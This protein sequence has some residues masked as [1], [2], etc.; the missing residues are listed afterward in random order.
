MR[1]F[2]PETEKSHATQ[3]DTMKTDA[4]TRLLK[5]AALI[6]NQKGF[7]NAGLQELL[8]KARVPKG[9]FYFHFKSKEDFGLKLVDFYADFYLGKADQI[10]NSNSGTHMERLKQYLDWQADYMEAK[11]FQGG[12]PFG[13]LSQEMADRNDRFRHKLEGVFT[14]IKERIARV[15]TEAQKS[16]E[17]NPALDIQDA[18]DFIISAWQGVLIQMKVFK[19]RSS[20]EAFNRMVFDHLLIP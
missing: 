13:N 16:H 9:S 7:Y 14:V 18:A 10:L 1:N 4:K 3:E 19:N 8:D 17:I 5:A 20:R 2:D 11:G 15:L 12:C 6:V